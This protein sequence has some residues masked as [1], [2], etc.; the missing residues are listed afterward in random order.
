M[1]RAIQR[2][3]AAATAARRRHADVSPVMIGDQSRAISLPELDATDGVA[4]AAP[5]TAAPP[6]SPGHASSAD[7]RRAPQVAVTASR[8]LVVAI[9]SWR[10]PDEH[11][12]RARAAR[13]LRSCA[14]RCQTRCAPRGRAFDWWLVA[15]LGE[16]GSPCMV[17]RTC[18][19]EPHRGGVA[20]RARSR[21]RSAARHAAPA[22]PAACDPRRARTQTTTH[23]GRIARRLAH[24]QARLTRSASRSCGR[25]ATTARSTRPAA[26]AHLEAERPRSVGC[27][28]AQGRQV[29]RGTPVWEWLLRQAPR[30]RG[31]HRGPR[32]HAV[33]GTIRAR[34]GAAGHLACRPRAACPGRTPTSRSPGR[35]RDTWKPAT[36]STPLAPTSRRSA[37]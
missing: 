1:S 24:R 4:V 27:R 20:R 8:V 3:R 9:T 13:A 26:G 17:D 5:V 15:A 28:S 2:S 30:P 6:W 23:P 37:T 33:A 10:G 21:R 34:P 29:D 36:A 16:R 25:A 14:G 11:G 22:S 7:R 35:G 12:D 31:P 19:P 32:P 18:P